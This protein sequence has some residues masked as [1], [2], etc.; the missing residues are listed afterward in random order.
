MYLGNMNYWHA[1][2]LQSLPGSL[3]RGEK[4][5]SG[6]L[7]KGEILTLLPAHPVTQHPPMRP[8]KHV[9]ERKLTQ[10]HCPGHPIVTLIS[11]KQKSGFTETVAVSWGVNVQRQKK[12]TLLRL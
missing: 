2:I 8:V 1:S 6:K 4:P 10:W 7:M 5:F 3:H 12:V 9:P 11:R